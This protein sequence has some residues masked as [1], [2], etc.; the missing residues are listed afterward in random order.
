MVSSQKEDQLKYYNRQIQDYE[1]KGGL[2]ARALNRAYQRKAN[3]ILSKLYEPKIGRIL[4]IGAGS[5]LMTYYLAESYKNEIVALDLSSE[6][7]EVA[8]GRL[9]QHNVTCAVGD[10]TNPEFAEDS[11]DAVIGVDIIHHLDDP[12]T[13]MKNWRRLVREG[14][15]MVFLETNVY[16]PINLRN[17]GVEHEVRSFLNTDKN[18]SLWAHDAGWGGVSAEPAPSFTPA[19]PSFLVPF[20]QLIDKVSPHIP[21]WKYM[22]ALW[23]LSADKK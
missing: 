12:R 7:L 10:G 11:F 1:K 22:A 6:M 18:L 16:N 23:L 3:I 17:I 19:G 9:D 2:L 14:G 5:G 13:A 4:E 8:K 21:Y 20:F 15:Q